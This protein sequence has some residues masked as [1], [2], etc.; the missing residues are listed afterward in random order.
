MT[1]PYIVHGML[2]GSAVLIRGI[3]M[4]LRS[5][6]GLVDG[7]WRSDSGQALKRLDKWVLIDYFNRLN[8]I[9]LRS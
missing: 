4:H 6:S 1:L 2:L 3:D 8:A 5:A 7:L 9:L